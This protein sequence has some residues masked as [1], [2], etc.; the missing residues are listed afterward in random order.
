MKR[1][2]NEDQNEKSLLR[3]DFSAAFVQDL[4]IRNKRILDIGC[5]F[6]W[7]E[8]NAIERGAL[9]VVA[10]EIT[11]HDLSQARE[12]LKLNNVKFC[13]SS[14]TDLQFKEKS[15]DTI[16]LWEVLEH[17]PKQSENK[18]FNKI[19]KILKDNG[20]FYLSTP[21]NH[22][23]SNIFDP[24]WWLIGH[25]HYNLNEIDRFAELNGFKIETFVIKGG[26][27]E[28]LAIW[29]LYITKWI[30]R[31]RPFLKKFF[32]EK[33]SKEYNQNYNGFCSLFC[34]LRTV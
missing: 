19:R 17:T 21:Y 1:I 28:V 29:N 13:V 16:V 32:T 26:I 7:F 18:V 2:L 24:T 11:E 31:R 34:K 30:F 9:S 23:L 5:G 20:V 8:K 27:W 15:F 4:D 22:F 12:S 3:L 6:G 33:L 10:T 14:A 25:R